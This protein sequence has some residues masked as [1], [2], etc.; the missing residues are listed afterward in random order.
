M[1]PPPPTSPRPESINS[2]KTRFHGVKADNGTTPIRSVSF[3]VAIFSLRSSRPMPTNVAKPRE[4]R[5]ARRAVDVIRRAASC[6]RETPR[7]ENRGWPMPT[8][9]HLCSTSLRFWPNGLKVIRARGRPYSS[10]LIP[11][12]EPACSR[13]PQVSP[14]GL[15]LVSTSF[16]TSRNAS[17]ITSS[18]AAFSASPLSFAAS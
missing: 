8:P 5:E 12:M 7:N 3:D 13:S 6:G 18:K 1:A 15:S 2:A 16:R 4:T 9:V 17:F 10:F 14:L 11:S